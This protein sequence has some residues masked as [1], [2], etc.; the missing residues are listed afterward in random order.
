MSLGD[1]EITQIII[2]E[3]YFPKVLIDCINKIIM[4]G[5]DQ[6]KEKQFAATNQAIFDLDTPIANIDMI[7][8]YWNGQKRNSND[9]EFPFT[10]TNAPNGKI[11]FTNGPISGPIDIKYYSTQTIQSITGCET[12]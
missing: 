1:K 3:Y 2:S 4:V 10:V 12:L 5:L 7:A 11:T 6:Q 8:L 9:P